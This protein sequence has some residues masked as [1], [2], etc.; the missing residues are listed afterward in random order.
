M[1]TPDANIE[2]IGLAIMT[3]L[4]IGRWAWNK[5]TGKKQ[6][7][8]TTMLDELLT[9][10]LEDALADG[11]VLDAIEERLMAAALKLIDKAGVSIPK[12]AVRIAVQATM[13]KARKAV[14]AR[15]A[16]QDAARKLPQDAEGLA[17]LAKLVAAELVKAGPNEPI[18]TITP[19]KEAGVELLAIGPDGK[20]GLGP[21]P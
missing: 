1:T 3:L 17:A 8:F 20:L 11:E 16:N 4:G 5:A 15:K 7:D 21:V 14:R 6:A 9:E 18:D 2:A 12:G 13:V 19:A 10:E